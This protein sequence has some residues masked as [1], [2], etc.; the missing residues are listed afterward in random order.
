MQTLDFAEYSGSITAS[1]SLVRRVKSRDQD[2]P[3]DVAKAAGMTVW[4]VYKARSRVLHRLRTE[5][6]EL[7]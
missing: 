4:A 6:D 1:T 7:S 5:L 2:A 3:A